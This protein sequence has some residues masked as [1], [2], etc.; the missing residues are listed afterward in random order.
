MQAKR[1]QRI[2]REDKI[3]N[4]RLTNYEFSYFTLVQQH[5]TLNNKLKIVNLRL[6]QKLFS[7]CCVGAYR[8]N[9]EM[10][11]VDDLGLS[12][13]QRITGEKTRN[14]SRLACTNL[15]L[16]RKLKLHSISSIK[17]TS[18]N[19]PLHITPSLSIGT[20]EREVY[21]GLLDG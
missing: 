8:H 6:V 5:T 9:S 1:K 4:Q 17:Q 15:Q 20:V 11:Q 21:G 7:I 12:L 18:M 2:R 13:I 14:N 3:A 16:K 19:F 10:Y